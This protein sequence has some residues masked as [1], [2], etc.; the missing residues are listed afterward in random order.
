[1]AVVREEVPAPREGVPSRP[2]PVDWL[3]W[4]ACTVAL[5][6]FAARAVGLG[7][8]RH[9]VLAALGTDARPAAQLRAR[10]ARRSVRAARHR[11]GRARLR[12][13]YPLP[14]RAPGAREPAGVGAVAVLAVDGAV[15][16][17]H[18]GA[19]HGTGPRADVR[20]LRRHGRLLVLPHRLRPVPAR[21][22]DRSLDGAAGHGGERRSRCS[23]PP[24][25][26]TRC[27][28]R[29]RSPS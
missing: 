26:S 19:G 8:R 16:G 29:S 1:M 5:A 18:G 28:A 13:R 22:A 24:C 17:R 7:L 3:G 12:L 2:L 23:W 6:G 9:R 10:R 4:V 20:V 25:C 21:V 14:H 27:T 15:R 11:G